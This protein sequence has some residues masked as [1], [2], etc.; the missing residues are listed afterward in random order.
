VATPSALGYVEVKIRYTEEDQSACPGDLKVFVNLFRL[1]ER[2]IIPLKSF[3]EL[4]LQDHILP[5]R[6]QYQLRSEEEG[7][8][9]LREQ[10]PTIHGPVA[11]I[12]D[13]TLG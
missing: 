11:N 5:L 13:Q 7:E 12:P 9:L 8:G 1:V 2:S 4:F 10:T 6:L 3:I